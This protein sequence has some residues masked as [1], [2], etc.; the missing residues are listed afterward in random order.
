ME[1]VITS[2]VTNVDEMD[3]QLI[4]AG[5][6]FADDEQGPFRLLIVDSIIALYRTEYVGRGELAERQ[7]R[8]GQVMAKLKQ[9]AEEFN[10][11]VVLTNQ[12]SADPGQQSAFG[13]SSKPVGGNSTL[14]HHTR[15]PCC[16]L[17]DCGHPPSLAPAVLAHASDTRVQLRKG[18]AEQ[19]IAKV[20]DSPSMP[21]QEASFSLGNG[22]VQECMD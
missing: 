18:K 11:A 2:R 20:T 10:L 21:E 12:V 16:A 4:E 22:G 13:P 6:L 5:G 1:N 9:L 3:E 14:R 19:R 7:Q 8:L 17:D 15:R